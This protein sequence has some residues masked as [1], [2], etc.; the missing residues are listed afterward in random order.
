MSVVVDAS[1][2]GTLLL[3][4]EDQRFGALTESICME[5]RLHVPPIW[6]VE[7]ANLLLKAFR[8]RRISEHERSRA[9]TRADLI[10]GLAEVGSD[11]GIAELIPF[12]IAHSLRAHDATYL[13]L[14]VH[15][16]LPLLTNDKPMQRA[17]LAANVDLLLP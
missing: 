2:I 1:A 17:A 9:S 12:A 14:A 8:H 11:V 4:D 7:V 13:H 16:R 15:L 3:P 5:A 6:R 10:A